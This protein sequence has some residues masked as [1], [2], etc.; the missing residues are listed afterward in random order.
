MDP[1]LQE[2]IDY[3]EIRKMLMTYCHGCDRGE[4]PRMQ[5]HQNDDGGPIQSLIA[6]LVEIGDH[7]LFQRCGHC[8]S[9]L[10]GMQ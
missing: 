3:H 6:K 8:D 7:G 1:A 9:T 4:G 10:T 2:L 5:N